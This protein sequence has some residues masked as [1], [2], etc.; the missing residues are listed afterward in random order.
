[1]NSIET[2]N[3]ITYAKDYEKFLSSIKDKEEEISKI[4]ITPVT[5]YKNPFFNNLEDLI[6]LYQHIKYYFEK[7]NI[8][9][10]K[11]Q[12]GFALAIAKSSLTYNNNYNALDNY[13]KRGNS[14]RGE[15]IC[16]PFEEIARLLLNAIVEVPLYIPNDAKNIFQ[17]SSNKIELNTKIQIISIADAFNGDNMMK[18][19]HFHNNIIDSIE[20]ELENS[21]VK[22]SSPIT[23]TLSENKEVLTRQIGKI[24]GLFSDR[25]YCEQMIKAIYSPSQYEEVLTKFYNTTRIA[26]R[27]IGV[28]EKTKKL[29][30]NS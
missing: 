29:G 9:Y 24:D 11:L 6:T 28:Y 12:E 15:T 7:N 20:E 8:Y 25:L 26:R 23:A 13:F 17:N 22:S 21:N 30:H 14:L 5:N 19:S 4:D 3:K 27:N 2:L 1:M 16:N 10:G 18:K